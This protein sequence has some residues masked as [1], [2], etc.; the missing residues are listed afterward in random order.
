[1]EYQGAP[2][3]TCTIGAPLIPRSR[4]NSSSALNFGSDDLRDDEGDG[5]K[6]D[7]QDLDLGEV[8]LE[9]GDLDLGQVGDLD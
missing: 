7:S 6:I 5:L 2:G 8:D 9:L 4:S 3:L 1:M